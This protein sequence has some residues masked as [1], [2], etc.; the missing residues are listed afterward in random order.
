MQCRSTL[1]MAGRHQDFFYA[2]RRRHTI[3]D[4]DWSSDA[5]PIYTPD[6]SNQVGRTDQGE[7]STKESDLLTKAEWLVGLLLTAT[8]LSLLLVRAIYADALSRDECA[9]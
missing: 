9:V 8:I 7:A 3:F 5:L 1:A 4:C 2:S 6:L